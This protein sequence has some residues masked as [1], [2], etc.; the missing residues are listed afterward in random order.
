MHVFYSYISIE[1]FQSVI[2]SKHGQLFF[3]VHVHITLINLT[4]T[5]HEQDAFGVLWIALRKYLRTACDIDVKNNR[6]I[7]T[8]EE[9][10]KC[11]RMWVKVEMEW[12]VIQ[13]RR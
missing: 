8:Q 12:A 9:R 4:E 3:D 6:T 5:H 2:S 7:L 1:K 11:F 10:C 13:G